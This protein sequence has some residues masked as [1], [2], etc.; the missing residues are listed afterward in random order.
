MTKQKSSVGKPDEV[1]SYGPLRISRYGRHV[2]WESNWPEGAFEEA[3]RLQV[4]QL[5]KIVAQIDVLVSEIAAL[6]QVLPPK[7]LLHRAWWEMA[8]RHDKI[9]TEA[10]IT[11]D[12]G[13][14]V[15]MIDYIQS[16]IASVTP[17]N[18]HRPDLADED[19]ASLR[20]KV[21]E[22][23]ETL[24]NPY[25]ICR[26]ATNRAENPNLDPEFEE[27]QYRAQV[28]WCN[29]RGHRYQVHEP[30]Y[31][32]DMFLPHSAALKEL[33][34][35]TGEEFVAEVTKV[36]RA[37][38]F[39]V[40]DVAES[41]ASFQKDVM[42][43]VEKKL[44]AS[45]AS[46]ASNTPDLITEVVE[47]NNW[48]ERQESVFGK[49]VGMDLFDLQKTTSLPEN[50]LSEL[51]WSPGAETEFFAEGEFRGWP[52][53]IWPIFKRPF[54]K[55]DGRYHCFDLYSLFDHLYRTM[56]R[57]ILR[58][59]PTYAE[60]W[61]QIQQEVSEGLPFKYLE[62]ILP[63][64]KIVSPVYYR[65][66]TDPGTIDWCETDGL[67]IYDDCLFVI[68]AKGGAFTYTPPATDF[69]A[70]VASL[71]NLVLKPATQGKRFLDYLASAAVVPLFNE[72][73]DQIGEVSK[74]N[75]RQITICTVTLDPFTEIAAQVQ[76]LQKIGLN[77]GSD[78]VWAILACTPSI[79]HS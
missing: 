67:V 64:A 69:P 44:A 23:F 9:E 74:K 34:G 7:L 62:R 16:V 37:L 73:R 78:P 15:R 65:W 58:L 3:Q 31:L 55:L 72:Q 41:L 11:H 50:L 71:K 10:E 28:Y 27:F 13:V 48:R 51:S 40:K 29:V 21:D 4:G 43:A 17:A 36:W 2:L 8:W 56:Q 38:S 66:R 47:E 76:H 24:N 26:S 25:Q 57:I 61:K 49:F 68:E 18:A 53:R 77:V 46:A 19:W 6:V 35:L 54:I 32:K 12:D 70:Y 33:F 63:Q 30:I 45:P 75:F 60:S 79:H 22:L 14:L 59:K 39:G 42:A 52:L 5:P 20:S 1:L